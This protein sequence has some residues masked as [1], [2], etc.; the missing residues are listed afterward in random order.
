[1]IQKTC[2]CLSC[3]RRDETDEGWIV[4]KDVEEGRTALN[5]LKMVMKKK[6]CS[7]RYSRTGLLSA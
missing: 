1:M 7:E 2:R 4:T 3:L 5:W 6:T